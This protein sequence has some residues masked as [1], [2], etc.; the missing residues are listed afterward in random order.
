LC[1]KAK[2]KTRETNC[3]INNKIIIKAITLKRKTVKHETLLAHERKNEKLCGSVFIVVC[4]GV[5]VVGVVVVGV[6]EDPI[7]FERRVVAEPA[8]FSSS[9]MPVALQRFAV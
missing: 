4:A 9:A 3:A 2:I 8:P 1:K 7:A 5:V 6:D